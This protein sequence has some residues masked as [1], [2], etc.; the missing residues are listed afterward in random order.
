MAEAA[1]LR[2]IL[3]DPDADGPRLVYA[4]WLDEHGDP[5]RAEFIR[6]QC[7]MAGLSSSDPL[8]PDLFARESHLL[9]EHEDGWLGEL[10]HSLVRWTFDRGFLEEITLSLPT[11]LR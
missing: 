6:L 3:A 4:D 11:Y 5:A 1:F 10:R 9:D 8:F 2:L 7:R